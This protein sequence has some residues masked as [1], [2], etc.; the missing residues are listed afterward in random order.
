[1][2]TGR[3]CN[4]IGWKTPGDLIDAVHKLEVY[5]ITVYNYTTRL[6]LK[7]SMEKYK[8]NYCENTLKNE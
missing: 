1:M 5:L 3:G 4:K 8:Q 2:D 7:I 6:K